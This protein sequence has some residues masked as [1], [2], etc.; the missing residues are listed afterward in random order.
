[1]LISGKRKVQRHHVAN[2]RLAKPCRDPKRDVS[3]GP[4]ERCDN[5]ANDQLLPLIEVQ[6]LLVGVELHCFL[7]KFVVKLILSS[8]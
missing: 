2:Q 6:L 7:D 4:L 8:L 3:L 1:M 5:K